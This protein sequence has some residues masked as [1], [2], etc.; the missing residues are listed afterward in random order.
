MTL[1]FTNVSTWAATVAAL[2][3]QGLTF[4]VG[5]SCAVWTVTLTGGY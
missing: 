3:A 1:E 5:H 4:E 2:T